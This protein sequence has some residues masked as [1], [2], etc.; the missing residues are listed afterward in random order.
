RA[1]WRAAGSAL[2]D[3]AAVDLDGLPPGFGGVSGVTSLLDAL[4]GR[5]FL[6]WQRVGGGS[7]MEPKRELDSFAI[8]WATLDRRRRAELAKLDAMQQYAYLRTCRRGFVLRYFGDPAARPRCAGCDN[9]L[10]THVE[11]A[12]GRATTGRMPRNRP[13]MK[14]RQGK[15]SSQAPDDLVLE[16]AD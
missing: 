10:G 3:G 14:G 11:V 12:G 13:A 2:E 15:P 5:Q 8:D 7:A 6:A 1:L 4:Q 9:C 16:A